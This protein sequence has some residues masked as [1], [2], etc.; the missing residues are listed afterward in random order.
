MR[1]A[2][3]LVLA[4]ALGPLGPVG[5]WG[6]GD[7]Q[8][9][10]SLFDRLNLDRLQLTTMGASFGY[11]RLSQ[12]EPTEVYAL[13]ADYGEIVPRWR[14]VFSTTYWRSR[15]TDAVIGR[16]VD[17]LSQVVVDPSGDDI[18]RPTRVTISDIVL[19]T[20][21]RWMPRSSGLLRPYLGGGFNAHVVNAEGRLIDG[22]FVERALDN[23]T[24]GLS[25]SAGLELVPLSRFSLLIQGRYDLVTGT[26]FSSLR[27]GASYRFGSPRVPGDAGSAGAAR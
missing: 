1:T 18:L 15:Y 19:G 11:A 17:S 23:V 26:R 7:V 10:G 20:E 13:H 6:G 25:G 9:Q 21:L 2:L 16:F 24:A 22:T 5:P 4:L 12:L 14:V 27:A 8:A 3:A